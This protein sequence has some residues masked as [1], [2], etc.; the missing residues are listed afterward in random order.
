MAL[1]SAM[2][3]S[4]ANMGCNEMIWEGESL[5]DSGCNEMIWDGDS[6]INTGC[7]EM[8]WDGE[9]LINAGGTPISSSAVLGMYCARKSVRQS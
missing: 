1:S 6:L 9:S 7:N 4:L 8:T 5:I 2:D 3:E